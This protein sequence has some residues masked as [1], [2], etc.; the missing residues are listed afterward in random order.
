M[1]EESMIKANRCKKKK[2][3]QT[4]RFAKIVKSNIKKLKVYFFDIKK[5]M[6]SLN[7]SRE[8]YKVEDSAQEIT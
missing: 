4:D 6:D 3:R 7:K 1:E 2:K 8:N 5:P